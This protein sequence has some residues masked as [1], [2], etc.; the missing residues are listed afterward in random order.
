M[1]LQQK[2]ADTWQI[3]VNREEAGTIT[4]QDEQLTFAVHPPFRGRHIGADGVRMFVKYAHETL[5]RS[6]IRARVEKEQTDAWHILEHA[7]FAMDAENEK[8]RFYSHEQRTTVKDD[9]YVPPMGQQVIYFAGG[10]FWGTERIF[11]MLDGVSETCVGYANGT[12]TDPVYECV[13]RGDTG[14][15]ECVRVTYDPSLTP[16]KTLLDAFFLCIDP[17]VQNRQGNDAGT[18]YQ[19]GIYWREEDSRKTI[20]AYVREKQKEY[21][22][23]HTELKPLSCFYE[24]EEYHQKY[25][26]KHPFGYCHITRVELE[27]V[28]LLNEKNVAQHRMQAYN[29]GVVKDTESL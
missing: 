10:C 22:E 29:I 26:D 28:R 25:L 5:G 12:V 18:Q 21:S 20:E 14:Y 7:G 27:K 2:T 23:F 8:E 9:S 19:T 6:V 3:L 13:L 4:L 11:Q 24:A 17:T 15:R 16:L 1:K